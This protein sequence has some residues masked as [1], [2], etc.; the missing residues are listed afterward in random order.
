MSLNITE[1]EETG[2]VTINGVKIEGYIDKRKCQKCNCFEVYYD[3]YDAYFCPQCNLWKESKCK[4]PDCDY[5][6][7]R[8]QK[9]LPIDE[10]VT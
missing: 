1:D 8:P 10:M 6:N 3:K 5:C 4:D 9:P 7:M 2:T